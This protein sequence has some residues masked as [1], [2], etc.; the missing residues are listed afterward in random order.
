M[1]RVFGHPFFQLIISNSMKVG[2]YTRVS[3][4]EQQTLPLQLKDLRQYAK[5][6]K[7]KI[8][9]EVTDIASGSS[10]RPKREALLKLAKQ[11]KID[12]ILVWRLDRFGRSLADLI[13]T[14]NEL[15][16]LGVGFV[17]LNESLDLTTPSGRA[18]AGMLAVFAEFER[19]ILRERVKAGI[20]EARSK[21]KAHGRP[22]TAEK[23]KDQVIKLKREGLNNSQ[24]A[25]KLNIGRSSVI[26][27]LKDEN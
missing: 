23:K 7:W 26:R 17:S 10:T 22:K 20:A 3:T 4:S 15:N 14:L 13:T 18:M 11:R 12:C 9:T 27:M 8:E 6:R 2:I 19:E 25:R 24:I 1:K 21:G 16:S 5:Q